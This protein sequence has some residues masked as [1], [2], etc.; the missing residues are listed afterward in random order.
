MKITKALGGGKSRRSSSSSA[1]RKAF[2]DDHVGGDIECWRQDSFRS[3]A[4]SVTSPPSMTSSFYQKYTVEDILFANQQEKAANTN[5]C[6]DCDDDEDGEEDSLTLGSKTTAENDSNSLDAVRPLGKRKKKKK[7]FRK[8]FKSGRKSKQFH[9][10]IKEEEDLECEEEEELKDDHPP[11]HKKQGRGR[12]FFGS[13]A[14]SSGDDLDWGEEH[15]NDNPKQ[16]KT[17]GRRRSFFGSS[18]ASSDD[19]DAE[20]QDLRI[21]GSGEEQPLQ[22]G[23]GPAL[24][25][26]ALSDN[27]RRNSNGS[28]SGR[29]RRN[30]LGGMFG[31]SDHKTN[32]DTTTKS[33]AAT[34]EV[35]PQKPPRRQSM[36]GST[37]T[38]F[39]EKH[40]HDHPDAPKAK[41]K[42]RRRHSLTHSSST[43]PQT[44]PAI[45]WAK[46]DIHTMVNQERIF[47][48]MIPFR[49]SMLLDSYAQDRAAELASSY[50]VNCSPCNYHGNVARGI[51]IQEIHTTIMTDLQGRS[52]K[53]ILSSKFTD[54]GMAL[55]PGNDRLMYMCTLFE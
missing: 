34:G 53:N 36:F 44:T 21:G 4:S 2:V 27:R 12:S 14:S 47:R 48:S 9:E 49:R 37:S 19:G 54:F 24:D 8:F 33:A 35:K 29:R 17:Q 30:S 3:I 26:S 38:S 18:G 23:S 10:S 51:S 45:N 22:D 32:F 20:F 28:R 16:H 43:T 1:V 25:N 6:E 42:P 50:G 11:K 7:G 55:I 31:G 52:R 5:S 13:T 46:L 41:Y 15:P 40:P 39:N